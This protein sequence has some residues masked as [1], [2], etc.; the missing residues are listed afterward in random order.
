MNE[1]RFSVLYLEKDVLQYVENKKKFN[2]YERKTRQ[3]WRGCCRRKD[4]NKKARYYLK[5]IQ[6]MRNLERKYR[7]VNVYTKY[8]E[9]LERCPTIEENIPQVTIIAHATD[10]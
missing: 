2:E 3:W 9:Q 5:Y 6:N 4:A 1:D 8:H 7:H 10:L